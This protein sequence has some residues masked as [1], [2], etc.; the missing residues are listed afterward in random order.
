MPGTSSAAASSRAGRPRAGRTRRILAVIVLTAAVVTAVLALT[1]GRDTGGDGPA[2]PATAA[3]PEQQEPANPE[4]LALARRDADDPL[5][6]GSP[7]APVVLIEYSDFQC[8]FC[9]R[10][11][12]ETKPDLIRDYVDK[13][14]LR[15]EWR[16]F[17]VFGAE[18]EQAARAGW[19]AG[20]Q[21]RFWQFHDEAY[22]EPRRRN[23][24]DFSTEKL[25]AMARTAGV[26]D[27]ARFEKDMAS[28][29]AHR[30]VTRDSDEGYGIGVTSTPAFLINGQP[31]LGAQPTDVFTD[32]IDE[33]AEQAQRKAEGD[34]DE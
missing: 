13:G 7:D 4:L 23:A 18:S 33:A 3:T 32:L 1:L 2:A 21:D 20:Q 28:D 29:A 8:P 11:A 26:E 17:P 6:V 31:V 27:L 10:F 22:G 24:G 14:V 16:N 30:A 9:G 12:R 19:A 34:G 25:L 5:A 15:M